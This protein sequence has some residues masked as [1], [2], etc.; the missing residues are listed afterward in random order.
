MI[1][2]STFLGAFIVLLMTWLKSK[3]P[4]M[5]PPRIAPLRPGQDK[6]HSMSANADADLNDQT[7]CT[8]FAWRTEKAIVKLPLSRP[9]CSVSQAEVQGV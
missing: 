7:R 8:L 9:A 4:C 1:T 2:V 6:T 5:P 3:Q